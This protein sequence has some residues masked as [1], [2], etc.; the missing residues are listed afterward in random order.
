MPEQP[1][2]RSWIAVAA[3]QRRA[4]KDMGNKRGKGRARK[5]SRSRGQVKRSLSD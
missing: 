4:A 5:D 2:T 3:H 1:K